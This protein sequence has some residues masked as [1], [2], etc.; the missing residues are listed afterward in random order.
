M[1]LVSISAV[2]NAVSRRYFL[3]ANDVSDM[4]NWVDALN[5]ASKITV[6]VTHTCKHTLHS[7]QMF[8]VQLENGLAVIGKRF[9]SI[10][11]QETAMWWCDRNLFG[12]SG[13]RSQHIA[14]KY[15]VTHLM[16][17]EIVNV[18]KYE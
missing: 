11:A 8:D 6:S 18:R 1:Q 7:K 17:G 10:S 15:R 4:K 9:V 2:I 13:Y 3:Q 16:N 5:R 12:L 14:H